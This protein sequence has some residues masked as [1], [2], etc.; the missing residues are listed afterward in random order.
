M[1]LVAQE[2]AHPFKPRCLGPCKIYG[3]Y[4]AGANGVLGPFLHI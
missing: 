1:R 2:A 3:L 4:R